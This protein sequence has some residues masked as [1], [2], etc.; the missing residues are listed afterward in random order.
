LKQ[1]SCRRSG[2]GFFRVPLFEIDQT[3]IPRQKETVTDSELP[4][5]KN[6]GYRNPEFSGIKNGPRLGHEIV[7]HPE[8]AFHPEFAK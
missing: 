7:L 5:A 2:Y 1:D 4:A 8:P 3:A 6:Q